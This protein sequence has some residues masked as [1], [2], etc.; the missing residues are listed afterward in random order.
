MFLTNCGTASFANRTLFYVDI[1]P[2]HG[3]CRVSFIAYETCIRLE[4]KY[5]EFLLQF[6]LPYFIRQSRSA[7]LKLLRR[8]PLSE[9]VCR[10]NTELLSDSCLLIF[11]HY[12]DNATESL[13]VDIVFKSNRQFIYT[14]HCRLRKH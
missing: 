1:C 6:I 10:H 12:A 11:C 14:L 8:P 2:Q 9:Y 13:A 3:R 4:F 7:Y 5:S